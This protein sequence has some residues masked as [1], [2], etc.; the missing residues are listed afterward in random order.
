LGPI[1]FESKEF[2]IAAWDD[3]AVIMHNSLYGVSVSE[4]LK[5]YPA[6]A[7]VTVLI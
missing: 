1:A 2:A 5:Q 4:E 7:I 3:P 6:A